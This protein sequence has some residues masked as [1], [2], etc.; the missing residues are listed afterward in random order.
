MKH[1]IA[2]WVKTNIS[3]F[4]LAGPKPQVL[5]DIFIQMMS[6]FEAVGCLAF[7]PEVRPFG[8]YGA[9]FMMDLV[10]ISIAQICLQEDGV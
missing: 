5:A 7:H 8:G 10:H 3:S 6:M 9:R 4:L 1:Y 2:N